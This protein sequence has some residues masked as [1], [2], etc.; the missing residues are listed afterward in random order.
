MP[1]SGTSG[2]VGAGGGKPPSA[3]RPVP[4]LPLARLREG[5]PQGSP[6]PWNNLQPATAGR[7]LG[8]DRGGN[9]SLPYGVADF[10]AP[11]ASKRRSRSGP[12]LYSGET[13]HWAARPLAREAHRI[14]DAG[15]LSRPILPCASAHRSPGVETCME[16][17]MTGAQ[18][19]AD[20]LWG[21]TGRFGG[22][23]ASRPAGRG[24][25]WRHAGSPSNVDGVPWLCPWPR[26]GRAARPAAATDPLRR[27]SGRDGSTW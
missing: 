19:P 13:H 27:G 11:P 4:L 9:F 5:R 17:T 8:R 14:R 23:P 20:R 10:A 15:R 7:A 25:P 12:N 1:E 26:R 24:P 22:I 6:L 18:R 3:T 21:A 16:Q 2:S